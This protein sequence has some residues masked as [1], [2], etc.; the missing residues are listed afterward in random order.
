MKNIFLLSNMLLMLIIPG[1]HA[2]SDFFDDIIIDEQNKKE[3]KQELKIQESKTKASQ[4]LDKKLQ[5]L[6]FKE[7]VK[8]VNEPEPVIRDTAPFGL[9]WLA[10]KK[11]IEDIGVKLEEKKVKDAPQSYMATDLPKPVKAFENVLVSFGNTDSLWRISGYGI[12]LDDDTNASNGLKEYQKFYD[13]FNE[14]YANAE[15]FYTPAVINIDQEVMQKD[16]TKSHIIKQKFV[17]KGDVDFKE[18]LMSGE[19]VLYST[20]HN[21]T[22]SVTLALMANGDGQTF[23]MVDYKNLKID[24][25]EHDKMLDAL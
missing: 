25:L 7:K 23:I 18:K 20:F 6:S 11:E 8:K 10:T 3:I 9:L 14:K 22:V 2:Q 19:S 17:E 24:E 15:E 12:P 5:D 21:E 4:M 1:V 13:L 16:G